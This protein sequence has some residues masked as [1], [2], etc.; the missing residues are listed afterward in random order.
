M[1][2]RRQ[3]ARTTA[4]Q[5]RVGSRVSPAAFAHMAP[6]VAATAIW[7]SPLAAAVHTPTL[8]ADD[9]RA[10]HILERLN[11]SEQRRAALLAMAA[12]VREAAAAKAEELQAEFAPGHVAF[13]ARHNQFLRVL[14]TG[15]DPGTV[16]L[17]LDPADRAT[18]AASG[19][20]LLEAEG[21]VFRLF[22]WTR[23]APE[24]VQAQAWRAALGAALA[25]AIR[26]AK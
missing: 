10:V 5:G 23:V 11:A 16:E 20:T 8:P 19:A 6:Q 13:I 26:M 4:G 22:G 2:S 17:F 18:L 25:K 24:Q 14:R 15:T 3:A 12:Q 7:H 9:E 1:R 21:A